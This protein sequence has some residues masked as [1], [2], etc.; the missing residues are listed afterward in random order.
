MINRIKSV[1]VYSVTT[2]LMCHLQCCSSNCNL[3]GAFKNTTPSSGEMSL[4]EESSAPTKEDKN[5][6]THKQGEKIILPPYTNIVKASDENLQ[7]WSM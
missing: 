4:L 7:F 3:L 6:E 5:R 2:V 1:L